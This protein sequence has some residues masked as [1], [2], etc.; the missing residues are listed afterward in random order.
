MQKKVFKQ[1]ST[2]GP[3]KSAASVEKKKNP[4]QKM[5]EKKQKKEKRE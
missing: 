1:T 5:L 2:Q 3:A 4:F